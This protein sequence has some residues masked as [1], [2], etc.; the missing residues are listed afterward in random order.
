[1]SWVSNYVTLEGGFW[2]PNMY[3]LCCAFFEGGY[4]GPLFCHHKPLLYLTRIS[5][6][7]V[8]GVRT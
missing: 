2:S 7:E 4:S 8:L 5:S 3:I 6:E 1:M